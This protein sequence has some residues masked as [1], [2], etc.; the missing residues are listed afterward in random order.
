MILEDDSN[1]IVIVNIWEKQKKKSFKFE[2]TLLSLFA[3]TI[4]KFW[5]VY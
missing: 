4:S 2:V 1:L 5:P 3:S